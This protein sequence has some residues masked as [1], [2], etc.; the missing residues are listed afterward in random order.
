MISTFTIN[1]YYGS[2]SIP[3]LTLDI[4]NPDGSFWI[5]P[6]HG[7]QVLV[8]RCPDNPDYACSDQG[9]V[10]SGKFRRWKELSQSP[11]PAGYK[12]VGLTKSKAKTKTTDVHRLIAKTWIPNPEGKEQVDHINSIRNDNRVCNLRWVTRR[13]NIDKRKI[14][15]AR[16]N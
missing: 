11:N 12:T 3:P 8:K 2:A 7:P 10:Y 9:I 16:F 1:N 14:G 4:I 15:I 13:E 6:E 5:L